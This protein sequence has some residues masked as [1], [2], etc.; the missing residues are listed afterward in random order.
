MASKHRLDFSLFKRLLRYIAPWKKGIVFS[1]IL[2][3][4]ARAIEAWIPIRL[5]LLAQD[6]LKHQGET[7]PY[8]KEG[9]FLLF[10]MGIDY[11]FDASSVVIKSWIGSQGLFKLRG[12]VFAHILRQPFAFFDKEKRAK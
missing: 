6:L 8:F 10:L 11:I 4:A 2:I 3:L 12:E 5:G 9:L 1:L 7:L